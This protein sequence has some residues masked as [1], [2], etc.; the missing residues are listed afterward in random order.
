MLT[1]CWVSGRLTAENNESE[2]NNVGGKLII[3]SKV[4]CFLA[5]FPLSNADVTCKNNH[6]S[7]EELRESLESR[8]INCW[9]RKPK[10]AFRLSRGTNL[11][12]NFRT[13]SNDDRSDTTWPETDISCFSLPQRRLL[14]KKTVIN[15]MKKVLSTMFYRSRAS[16]MQLKMVEQ[17]SW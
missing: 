12:F 13:R 14:Q 4:T 8:P 10:W 16:T 17:M 6:D 15:T 9:K 1:V 5:S 2:N 3:V 11:M 7:E